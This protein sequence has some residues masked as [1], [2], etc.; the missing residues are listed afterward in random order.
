MAPEDRQKEP[1]ARTRAN[2]FKDIDIFISLI[3]PNP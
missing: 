3:F 1:A 2:A